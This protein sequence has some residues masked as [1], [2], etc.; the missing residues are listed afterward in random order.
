MRRSLVIGV[1]GQDGSYLAEHLLAQG[2]EVIGLGRQQAS[3][4]VAPHP[5]Y[6][7]R[8]LDLTAAG[9]LAALLPETAPDRIYHL[10]ALH[11]A[12]G[13]V[14]E[15]KWQDALAVNLGSVHLCLEHIRLRAPATRLLYASSLKAFGSPPP[16]VIVETAPR[17][18]TCLYS[19]TKNAA[20]D[21][22]EYYRVHHRVRASVLFL[23]NHESPRRPGHFVLPRMVALLAAALDGRKPAGSLRSLDF[24]CDWGSSAEYMQLG[25][26]VLEDE[27]N[28]DYVMATGRTWSGEEV[29]A[30]LFRRAGLDWRQWV[31]IERPVGSEPVTYYE[32]DVGR[33]VETLGAGPQMS[34]VDVAAWILQECHGRAI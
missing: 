26:R 16:P 23:L 24:V 33:L 2:G 4:Y 18:S 1:N 9:A 12:S 29:L 5:R 6:T 17:R 11:G 3:R 27:R 15:D 30:E 22:I 25:C 34:A 7:Y 21:L 13:F 20:T 31:E 10:A 14:Y 32:A 19:I 28:Q 8:Q